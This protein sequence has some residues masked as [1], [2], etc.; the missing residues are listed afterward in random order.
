MRNLP[1]VRGGRR[2]CANTYD[3]RAERS[4][5]PALRTGATTCLLPTLALA[6]RPEIA[7]G[8]RRSPK[9]RCSGGHPGILVS[10]GVEVT[11]TDHDGVYELPARD[12]VF[13]I[14][15]AHWSPPRNVQTG[16]PHFF[17]NHRPHGSPAGLRYK[18]SPPTG[19]STAINRFCIGPEPERSTFHGAPIRRSTTCDTQEIGYLRAAVDRIA[20][21]SD[22]AFGLAL[23]ISRATISAYTAPI[24]KRTARLGARSGT[25]PAI[26]ITTA[27]QRPCTTGGHMACEL[28]ARPL[29][30]SSTQTRSSLCWTMSSR[31]RAASTK[32]G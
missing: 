30:R 29:M 1:D 21:R 19:P 7:R 2:R 8:A 17:Y 27:M 15:P 14:K 4:L 31:F 22:F 12:G 13:V 6:L 5:H 23:G 25:S 24:F 11:H 9:G 26:T 18:G 32:A 16:L 3:Q 20:C 10:N 28:L